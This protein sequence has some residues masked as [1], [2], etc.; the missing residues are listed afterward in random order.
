[1]L[2]RITAV[3]CILGILLLSGC[4]IPT[5]SSATV[6]TA[7][8]LPEEE[9]IT[10]SYDETVE[11]IRRVVKKRF[12]HQYKFYKENGF[13]DSPD[14][15]FG[16]YWY[17]MLDD[18]ALNFEKP[19]A[20]DYGYATKD[21]NGDGVLELFYIRR[22]N[23]IYSVFTFSC[24]NTVMLDTYY[25]KRH[26]CL[27]DDGSI[28]TI[29]DDGEGSLIYEIKVLPKKGIGLVTNMAFAVQGDNYY[30]IIEGRRVPVQKEEFDKFAGKLPNKNNYKFDFVSFFPETSEE[31]SA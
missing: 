31:T 12:T 13:M 27:L 16:A 17:L 19:T 25:S 22:D 28:L 1:M 26:C 18:M 14:E 4:T 7:N 30:K 24:D 6:M 11:F 10:R 15:T 3:L 5:N 2:K 20:A 23:V 21:I 29:T 9:I 8:S